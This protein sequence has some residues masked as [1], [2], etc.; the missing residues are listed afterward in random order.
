MIER[1]IADRGLFPHSALATPAGE[2][3][4]DLD[5]ARAVAA[6]I[7]YPVALKAQA[8]ALAHKTEAGGVL[9]N[10]ADEAAL[11]QGMLS[12]QAYVN[13]HSTFA[14]AGEIRGFLKVPEP[15]SLALLGVGLLGFAVARRRAARG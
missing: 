15:G 11:V 10:L 7:G 8:A 9:L 5:S 1:R 3:A 13:I 2:L 12:G 6:R 4:R 14:P